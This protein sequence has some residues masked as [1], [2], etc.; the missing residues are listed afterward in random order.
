MHSLVKACDDLFLQQSSVVLQLTSCMLYAS[1]HWDG[2][3]IHPFAAIGHAGVQV[4]MHVDCTF[5]TAT[6][7]NLFAEKALSLEPLTSRAKERSRP[8]IACTKEVYQALR[9]HG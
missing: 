8:D 4:I 7:L 9:P 5:L 3:P 2:N 1:L 6:E